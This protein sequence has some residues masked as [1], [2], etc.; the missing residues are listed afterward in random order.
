VTI[1]NLKFCEVRTF[2]EAIMVL[3]IGEEERNYAQTNFHD[4]SSRSHTIFQVVSK[5]FAFIKKK[6]K[7]KKNF[8]ISNKYKIKINH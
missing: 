8:S 2:E 6:K 1:Q 7:K 3:K 4:R 5:I